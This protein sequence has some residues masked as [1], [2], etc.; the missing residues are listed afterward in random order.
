MEVIRRTRTYSKMESEDPE[1][2]RHRLAQFLINK[3]LKQADGDYRRR[4][5]TL[6]VRVR[7]LTVKIG[8]RFKRM[9]KKVL[10][11]ISV[12][13]V[14]VHKQVMGQLKNWKRYLRSG[15]AY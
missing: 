5:L 9:K 7:R 4:N 6:R 3:V 12:A 13:K 8:K 1:E 14:R 11:T 15:K 10:F 2:R